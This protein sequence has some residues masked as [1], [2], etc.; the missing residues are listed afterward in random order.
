MMAWVRDCYVVPYLVCFVPFPVVTCLSAISYSF[1]SS[2]VFLVHRASCIPSCLDAHLYTPPPRLCLTACTHLNQSN[3]IDISSSR[4]LILALLA[5][6]M[7]HS[8]GPGLVSP[9][10]RFSG[11]LL[12]YLEKLQHVTGT[13][14]IQPSHRIRSMHP[15]Q[16]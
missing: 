5:L 4:C 6:Y 1:W 7:P 13:I 8:P 16:T 11:S 3:P 2:L 9:S 14:T 15:P 10:P 12:S